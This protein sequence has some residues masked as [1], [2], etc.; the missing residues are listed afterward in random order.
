MS[1]RFDRKP[2]RRDFLK[3][4][5]GGAGAAAFLPFFDQTQKSVSSGKVARVAITSLSVYKEPWD[6]SQ[7]LYQ[8]FRDDL[9]NVYYEVNS[10]HGPGYNPIWY[11]IW[12]GYVHSAHTQIVETRLNEVDYSVNYAPLPGMIGEVTVPFTQS[13]LRNSDGSWRDAFRLYYQSVHWVVGVDSGPDG[14]PWYRIKDEMFDVDRL[15][16]FIPAEHMRLIPDNEISP[17]SPEV[18]WQNKRIEISIAMQQ[19]T[20]YEYDKQ[21]LKTTVSTGVHRQRIEGQIPTATPTG[22]FNIQNKM[23]SKHMG[24]GQ[25]TSDLEAYELPGVPWVCF[26]EP[27]TGVATHGTYW[28]TNFGM[29][30]SRGCIN[31]T[32]DTAKWLY[33]WAL[34]KVIDKRIETIGYG[35]T[36]VVS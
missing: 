22:T 16:Y 3:F 21:V 5:A 8:K 29:T 27:V 34:P 25:M 13:R 24:D 11:R 32:N 28:H 20:A 14:R 23:P 9:L 33:R 7:I 6:E 31:M 15:D 4:V 26:F 30:M 19:L 18:P 12:G 36:V 10:E 2:D 17:L 1:F 35:T